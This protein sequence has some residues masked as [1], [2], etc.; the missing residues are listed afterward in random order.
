[1]QQQQQ[2]PQQQHQQQQQQKLYHNRAVSLNYPLSTNSILDRPPPPPSSWRP[3]ATTPPMLPAMA[4]GCMLNDGWNSPQEYLSSSST[5]SS[6]SSSSNN[7]STS[8]TATM[9][10]SP[11]DMVLLHPVQNE[12]ETNTSTTNSTNINNNDNTGTTT[13]SPSVEIPESLRI[14]GILAAPT[15]I[16]PKTDDALITYLNRGQLYAIDL[17]DSQAESEGN[18]TM[19]TT[20]ISITF[21]E[22][23]HRQ[24][25]N[26]YW[27]FWLSQQRSSDARAISIDDAHCNGV[28]NV[29]FSAFDRI[30]FDWDAHQGSRIHVRFHCLSTDFS[31]IKG[32][33]GIP[34][35]IHIQHHIPSLSSPSSSTSYPGGEINS[36]STWDYVEESFCKIKLF[37]DKGAERKNKDNSKQYMKHCQKMQGIVFD[38]IPQSPP[39]KHLDDLSAC[40]S[41]GEFEE[42]SRDF[43]SAGGIVSSNGGMMSYNN[44]HKRNRVM[45]APSA[46]FHGQQPQPPSAFCA[47]FPTTT[48]T[49]PSPWSSFTTSPI[50]AATTSA[51]TAT[52]TGGYFYTDSPTSVYNPSSAVSTPFDGYPTSEHHSNKEIMLPP[53]AQTMPISSPLP[54]VTST[55]SC[56]YNTNSN[57][58]NS[59]TSTTMTSMPP[60]PLVYHNS[61]KRAREPTTEGI[62]QPLPQHHSAAT[63]PA[64]GKRI[65]I[66][67]SDDAEP[68]IIELQE[69]TSH[70]LKVKLCTVLSLHP[71]QVSHIVWRPKDKSTT[72]NNNNSNNN[73]SSPRKKSNSQKIFITMDDDFITQ[74]LLSWQQPSATWE[75][76]SDGTVRIILEN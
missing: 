34:L 55:S 23:S 33:K 68:Q 57:N 52:T 28:V 71:D 13:T 19:I 26:N 75:I 25:A 41:S 46:L 64:L 18:N 54:P 65:S 73:T 7:G 49:T 21:H 16:S 5:G 6:S 47:P 45:T 3:H 51:T 9:T 42:L 32:V 29:R 66:R 62:Q 14:T 36:S 74:D 70:E 72:F 38:V 40:T 4:Y 59:T 24:V 20:T 67:T 37:R 76:K 15:A 44:N 60:P 56:L 1:S 53:T 69:F 2:N 39:L 12:T 8:A 22:K 27:K 31:R 63:P 17:K 50:G 48:F 35:R 61:K 43:F 58:N 11:V 10:P 30:T